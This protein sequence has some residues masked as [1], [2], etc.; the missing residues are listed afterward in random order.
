MGTITKVVGILSL[1][2][3]YI[4]HCMLFFTFNRLRNVRI[5]YKFKTMQYPIA[6]GSIVIK[7]TNNIDPTNFI[8]VQEINKLLLSLILY[9]LAE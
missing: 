5:P 3:V 7:P 9:V 1:Y 2:G 4:G 8:A 6:N